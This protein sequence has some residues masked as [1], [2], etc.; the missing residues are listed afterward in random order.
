LKSSII[1]RVIPLLPRVIKPARYIGNEINII[2]KELSEV[3]L[4]MVIS[5]PDVYEIGM[6]NLGIRLLYHSVNQVEH[7]YCER[8]FAPWVDFEKILLEHDI[9]LYSLETFT[10]L[11]CFDVIG[12]SIGYELLGTNVLSI[13]KL[14]KIP[15]LSSERKLTY[16][17]VIAGGPGI[18]NPEPLADFIDVFLFGDGEV[19]LIE[20][21][22]LIVEMKGEEKEKILKEVDRFEFTYVPSSYRKY[23]VKGYLFTDIKK[24]VKRRI[25]PDL[26]KLPYPS[27]P[28]LPLTRIVQDRITLELNRGCVNGCR[29]CQAGYTYRPL[30]ERSPQRL[31]S[32]LDESLIATGYDEVSLASL[33]VSDY[34]ALSLLTGEIHKLYSQMFVSMSFPSLRVNSTNIQILNLIKSVR[35]SGL[36]FA[37]ESA[38]QEARKMINKPV[39]EEQL[40]DIITQL[41]SMGWRLIKFYFMIGLPGVSDEAFKTVDFIKRISKV[42]PGLSFNINI[43]VFVPKAHTPFQKEQ[44]LETPV[45]RNII[46]TIRNSFNSR[47]VNIKFQD[48][49]MS[50]I[51]GILSRGDRRIGELIL[52]VFEMGER[53]SSWNELFNYHRWQAA[54]N[55]LS[56]D[57]SRYLRIDPSLPRLPWD[58]VDTGVKKEYLSKEKSRALSKETT[59]GCVSFPCSGCGVCNDKIKNVLSEGKKVEVNQIKRRVY[60]TS[61]SE[62]VYRIIFSFK[63]TGLYRFISHLD[64]YTLLVRVGRAAGVPFLY[65][66]GYNPKPRLILPFPLPLG[67][68]SEYEL[69]EAVVGEPVNESVFIAM[70]NERLDEGLKLMKAE[71]IPGRGSITTVQ[72]FHDY[73]IQPLKDELINSIKR[74]GVEEKKCIDTLPGSYYVLKENLLFLRLDGK[75]SIKKL[76]NYEGS[77]TNFSITR[78]MLW[79]FQEGKLFPFIY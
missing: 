17:L 37:V 49:E 23:K 76:L 13:L 11:Y 56:I 41:S 36:T 66:E 19:A 69:G 20:F 10:P 52:R 22:N 75:K 30:R 48:P 47:R 53:F 5:Y 57:S 2:K 9:P 24:K 59:Q 72:F 62:N 8:V 54:M 79:S 26:D 44:Q 39:D 21:L 50:E 28:L 15:L 63:K 46:N 34:S 29:F 68:E 4:R 61:S 64:I 43:S 3:L 6:S 40:K 35:K 25:E 77:F 58:F 67:V 73:V 60:K 33:S 27:K 70:Y 45:A 14:G 78:K 65:S 16:P 18:Y 38:D 31:I 42:S 32:I 71:V 12:F 7:F 51:E 1:N 55:E 74:Q